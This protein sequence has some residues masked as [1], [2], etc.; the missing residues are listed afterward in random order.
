MTTTLIFFGKSK[1]Q[2]IYKVVLGTYN[3]DTNQH[4]SP[5]RV[6]SWNC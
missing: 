6:S 3:I 4:A 1:T 5:D 2:E